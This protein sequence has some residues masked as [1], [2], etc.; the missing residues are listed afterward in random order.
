MIEAVIGLVGV[1]VGSVITISKDVWLSWL[2]RRREGSYSAIRL[3]CILE[4]YADRCIDVVYDDGTVLGLPARRSDDGE[5]YREAQVTTPVPLEYTND[6]SW[7]SIQK[8]LMHRALALSNKARSTDRHIFDANE[9]ACPPDFTEVFEPRQEGYAQLGLDAL[10]LADDLRKKFDISV[11][12]RSE[13][14]SD[15]EPTAF[16]KATL[17]TFSQRRAEALKDISNNN[18]REEL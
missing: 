1:V 7:R 18:S 16:L 2:E 6:I 15:W 14:N 13:L 12:S 11:K 8:P 3:I 9:H 10:E 17:S 5:Y 4:E